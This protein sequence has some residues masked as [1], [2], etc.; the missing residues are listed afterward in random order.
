[1]DFIS[2]SEILRLDLLLLAPYADSGQYV[3]AQQAGPIPMETQTD[4]PMGQS[5]TTVRIQDGYFI[6][7]LL[8]TPV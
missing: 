4:R 3:H 2:L 1:M 7:S 8:D 6:P 5:H